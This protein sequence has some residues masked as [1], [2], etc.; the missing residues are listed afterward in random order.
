[1]STSE[2]LLEIDNVSKSYGETEAL[3]NVN[4]KFESGKVIGI[5]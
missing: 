4:V 2:Y 3:V 5:I 1:M